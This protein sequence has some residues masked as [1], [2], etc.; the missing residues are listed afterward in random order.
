M[1][2]IVTD[3]VC[4]LSS[5]HYRMKPSRRAESGSVE[6]R[7]P[8]V[9]ELWPVYIRTN[10][11]QDGHLTWECRPTGRLARR[12][13]APKRPTG[14][15]SPWKT[16]GTHA[17]V[18]IREGGASCAPRAGPDPTEPRHHTRRRGHAHHQLDLTRRTQSTA[19]QRRGHAHHELDLTRANPALHP[20]EE[21]HAHHQ[22]DLTGR[23]QHTAHQGG[24]MRTTSWT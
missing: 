14:Y 2:R 10:S 9:A 3:A 1:P 15:A 12:H 4:P 6:L 5:P 22:L 18:L 21:S 19:H 16:P 11:D 24:D 20:E 23:T 13:Q 7:L 17:D 8:V